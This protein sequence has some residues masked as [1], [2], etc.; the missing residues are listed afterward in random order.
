VWTGWC[1]TLADLDFDNPA[2]GVRWPIARS[3]LLPYWRRATPILDHKPEFIDFERP[4][5]RCSSSRR[6]SCC[7]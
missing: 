6:S 2:V 3:E 7:G 1:T 5:R 4:I